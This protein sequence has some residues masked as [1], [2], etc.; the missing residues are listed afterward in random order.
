MHGFFIVLACLLWQSAVCEEV[1]PVRKLR[2]FNL[3]LHISVIADVKDIF[4]SMGHEVV[5]WSISGHTWVFG[6]ERDKVDIVNEN[7]WSGLN[8]EMCDQFYER[9]KDFLDQFDGFIVTHTPAFALLYEKCNKPIIIV[10]STR[11][12]SP[13]TRDP[14]AW[15]HLNEYLR[16]GIKK[17]KIFIVSN[18]KG[19][20]N[21]L[22]YYSGIESDVIPSLCLYTKCQYKGKQG[23]F[24]CHG[25]W[26]ADSKFDE[27]WAKESSKIGL[28]TGLRWGYAWQ[29]L[30]DLKGV[31]H[32][33]YQVST[34][35]L[36]EQY[37]ANVPVFFPTKE[38]L[39][40]LHQ[41]Y[42]KG[43]LCHLSFLREPDF[44]ARPRALNDLN[45][46]MNLEVV[47]RWIEWADYY[48]T[49]NM[50]YIQY[51]DSFEHLHKLLKTANCRK[52]SQKMKEHCQVRNAIVF[53]KWQVIL[54]KI[55]ESLR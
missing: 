18:N 15:D 17:N 10:N 30:Y 2:F 6:K 11:Y 40:K 5:N 13:F 32:F 50:P 47:R 19:D 42:P 9:Y 26:G 29:E 27:D 41:L 24:A 55:S 25:L 49:E 28:F 31:V 52:I 39:F 20:S 43:I 7:T 23:K 53:K 54:Q 1:E 38:F 22:R 45:N 36:F 4:E 34:M 51:F 33:P 48:D 12:E 8:K 44:L 16:E 46:V 37:S 21:Y 35:S 14:E 3:D